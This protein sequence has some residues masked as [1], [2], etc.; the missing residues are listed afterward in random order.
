[1]DRHFRRLVDRLNHFSREGRARNCGDVCSV[2]RWILEA[3]SAVQEHSEVSRSDAA[4]TGV[5]RCAVLR[6]G[7]A[8]AV[9][10]HS[11][12]PNAAAATLAEPHTPGNE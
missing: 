7:A 1:M 6:S 11:G 5:E 8:R 12:M 10:E 9:M 3:A 4:R 2:G